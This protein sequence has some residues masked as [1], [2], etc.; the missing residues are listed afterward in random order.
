VYSHA[1]GAP[2]NRRKQVENNETQAQ[3]EPQE[4]QP[5]PVIHLDADRWGV[6]YPGEEKWGE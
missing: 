6:Y 5:S 3:P 4:K 1:A 2:T